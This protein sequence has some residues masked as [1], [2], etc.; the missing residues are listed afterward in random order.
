MSVT[1]IDLVENE[2]YIEHAD[3]TVESCAD[4][5]KAKKAKEDQETEDTYR[6]KQAYIE[7]GYAALQLVEA[8]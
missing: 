2:S 6:L 8:Y 1:V 4:A 7:A 5:L 3:G